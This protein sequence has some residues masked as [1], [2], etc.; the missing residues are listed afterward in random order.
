MLLAFWESIRW[1]PGIGDPSVA[2]WLTALAYL[3]VGV[4]ALGHAR[5]VWRR[6]LAPSGARTGVRRVVIF[7]AV[8]G[9]LL[10]LLA[11]NKQLDLQSLLTD[12]GRVWSKRQG[13]FD[14][15]QSVQRVFIVAVVLVAAAALAVGVGVFWGQRRR[16]GL[17][18]L[19]MVWLGGFV[20]VRAAS[21]HHVDQLLGT[22]VEGLKVNWLAELGGIAAVAAGLGVSVAA[23]RRGRGRGGAA[24]GVGV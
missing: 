8:A 17:G 5:G 3:A 1:R 19:G 21:F 2:G 16:L 12:V 22:R 9:G 10:V 18:L 13:W 20:V 24:E 14:R 6:E 7:W 23:G 11:L 4:L 15:R